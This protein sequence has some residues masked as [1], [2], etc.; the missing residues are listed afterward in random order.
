MPRISLASIVYAVT[1]DSTV[2]GNDIDTNHSN[3]RVG[4]S[5]RRF[6]SKKCHQM[7]FLLSECKVVIHV[8]DAG[9]KTRRKFVSLKEVVE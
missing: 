5:R 6:Q 9:K 3:I 7:V 1:K 2:T 4:N 8:Q